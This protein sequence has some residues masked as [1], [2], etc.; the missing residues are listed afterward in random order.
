MTAIS[1]RVP[2]KIELRPAT[3][4]DWPR[5]SRWLGRPEIIRW[6]GPRAT[7]EAEVLLALGSKQAL[8]RIIE[9]P[10][11]GAGGRPSPIGY[12]H[13]F[14]GALAQTDGAASLPTGSWKAD[15]FV[16]S[17]E[18]RGRGVGANAVAR[19][20]DEVLASTLAI[21]VHVQIGVGREKAVRAYEAIGFRW[22]SIVN[23]PDREPEWL[24]VIER[25]SSSS[26]TI[27]PGGQIRLL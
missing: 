9:A 2:A 21:A 4:E 11:N 18:H 7:T 1:T 3:M 14:D 26:A 15:V 23:Q 25:K 8:C 17:P 27:Q 13:A 22:V 6:W 16:A 12:A 10:D 20:V 19:L 5:I 24:M